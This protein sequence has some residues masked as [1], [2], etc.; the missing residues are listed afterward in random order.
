MQPHNK[1]GV[2]AVIRRA[3]GRILLNLRSKSAWV[4]PAHWAFFGG[5]VEEGESWLAALR[6]ELHEELEFVP[7]SEMQ[8]LEFAF[9]K[10]GGFWILDYTYHVS[11]EP[12]QRLTLHEGDAIEWFLVETAL[13]LPNLPPHERGVLER[14]R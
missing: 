5:G 1:R 7:H 13:E 11:W 12:S 14:L 2:S 6:R 3:D 10:K 4:Y 8:L 9:H